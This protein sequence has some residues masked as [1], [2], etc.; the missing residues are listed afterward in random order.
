[1]NFRQVLYLYIRLFGISGGKEKV[2][3]TG[4]NRVTKC[5]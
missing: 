4:L 2:K 1:M 5:I 3:F